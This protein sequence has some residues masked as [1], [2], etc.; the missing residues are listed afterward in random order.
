MKAEHILEEFLK[1]AQFNNTIAGAGASNVVQ[2]PIFSGQP[3]NR[4]SNIPT[5][6]NENKNGNVVTVK[7][8]TNLNKIKL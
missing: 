4:T 7:P 5:E 2:S 8:L 1:F 6:K 3:P